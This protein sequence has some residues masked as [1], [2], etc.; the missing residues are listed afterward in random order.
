MSQKSPFRLGSGTNFRSHIFQE[1]A[2]DAKEG[3]L[4]PLSQG[5]DNDSE[6]YSDSETSS[7]KSFDL[8]SISQASSNMTPRSLS[9]SSDGNIHSPL[10]YNFAADS[11]DLL[12]WQ[13]SIKSPSASLLEKSIADLPADSDMKQTLLKIREKMAKSL[14]RLKELEEQVKN[15]PTLQVRISVLQ[16]EKRQ[17]VKQL[18][19]KNT[20]RKTRKKDFS[21]YSFRQRGCISDTENDDGDDDNEYAT[22]RKRLRLKLNSRSVGVGNFSINDSLCNCPQQVKN[23]KTNSCI[24]VGINVSVQTSEK[25]CQSQMVLP[26]QGHDVVPKFAGSPVRTRSIGVGMMRSFTK[27]VAV[28]DDMAI[29]HSKS[30]FTQVIPEMTHSGCDPMQ[31]HIQDVGVNVKPVVASVQVSADINDTEGYKTYCRDYSCISVGVQTVDCSSAVSVGSGI[32]TID[33]EFCEKCKNVESN[34]ISKHVDEII[35]NNI[36]LPVFNSVGVGNSDIY[37]DYL[38]DKCS[39]LETH[40]IGIGE[41]LTTVDK[42]SGDKSIHDVMCDKCASVETSSCGVGDSSVDNVICDKC[43]NLKTKSQGVGSFCITDTYCD[44]CDSRKTRTVGVGE[45]GFKDLLCDKCEN[46]KTTSVGI[47]CVATSVT[48]GVSECCISDNYCDRCLHI[49]TNTVGVGDCCVTDSFCERC[50]NVQ[51]KSV[52]VGDFD[53]NKD[54]CGSSVSS[55]KSVRNGISTNTNYIEENGEVS[56]SDLASLISRKYIQQE[57][58]EGLERLKIKQNGISHSSVESDSSIDQDNPSSDSASQVSDVT[59]T[60]SRHKHPSRYGIHCVKPT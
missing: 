47:N 11:F 25:S 33:D 29:K 15:V 3:N 9:P 56:H 14:L 34:R 40:S 21:V 36:D 30:T 35:A 52:G 49:R 37:D 58:S 5:S 6:I 55:L 44:K 51:M 57:K 39:C 42:S 59:E 23:D 28:G 48:V 41:H 60:S 2:K 18:Q 22:I 38:C 19:A 12:S 31:V 7:I 27:D 16:E 1:K 24:S 32:C 45:T 26:E 54:T 17:L 53:V 20:Q 46:T 8:E 13:S 50:F 10:P 4:R 43:I